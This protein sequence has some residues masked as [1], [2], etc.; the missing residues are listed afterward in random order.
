L[1]EDVIA[2]AE[3]VEGLVA[4]WGPES[5]DRSQAKKLARTL[6]GTLPV[7][8][9]T[10]LTAPVAYRWK[11]QLNENSKLAAFSSELPELD[12]N[13][14]VGWPGAKEMGL[15]LSAVFLDDSFLHERL[16][17]RID[18]TERLIGDDAAT[19]VRVKGKGQSRLERMLSLVLLGDLVSLY[20]AILMDVD[21]VEIEVLERLKSELSAQPV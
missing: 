18:L 7:I 8:C 4:V 21:P 16:S 13:E 14:L 2:A 17:A 11:C 1:A 15:P 19:I 6:L 10:D 3:L 9:G 20:M 5:P 12:H